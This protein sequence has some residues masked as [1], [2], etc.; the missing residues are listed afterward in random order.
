MLIVTEAD[1]GKS[2][3]LRKGDVLMVNLG[4][5]P[6]NGSVWSYVASPALQI[7]KVDSQ[8]RSPGIWEFEA[9]AVGEG[10]VTFSNCGVAP[11]KSYSWP[12]NISQ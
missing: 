3:F 10:T 11:V 6:S 1:Q 9:E 2:L 12:V 4:G 7:R 8:Q 5:N